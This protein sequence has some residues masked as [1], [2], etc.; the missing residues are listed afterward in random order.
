MQNWQWFLDGLT[1]GKIQICC[2]YNFFLKKSFNFVE[3]NI[4]ET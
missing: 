2:S 3:S 1:L 4:F